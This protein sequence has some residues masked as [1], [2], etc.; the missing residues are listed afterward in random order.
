M[1]LPI[2]AARRGDR[3]ELLFAAVHESL[4]GTNR[5]SR[6]GLMMS[7]DQGRP[8]VTFTGREDRF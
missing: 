2:S 4:A 3:I 1:D 8:D 5:T 7:V 6:A